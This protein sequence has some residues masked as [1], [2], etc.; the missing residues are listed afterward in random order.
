MA[1]LGMEIS[2][3]DFGL[4]GIKEKKALGQVLQNLNV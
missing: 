2:S 4:M 1:Q 3:N